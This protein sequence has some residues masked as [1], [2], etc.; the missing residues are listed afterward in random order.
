M[1]KRKKKKKRTEKA[2]EGTR[3]RESFSLVP[4][5]RGLT[6]PDWATALVIRCVW[7]WSWQTWSHMTHKAQTMA[8]WHTL[9]H[10]NDWHRHTHTHNSASS[11][12]QSHTHKHNLT[13]KSPVF[14]DPGFNHLLINMEL[15]CDSTHQLTQ[16]TFT[17]V[18]TLTWNSAQSHLRNRF[19]H[20]RQTHTHT[21]LSRSAS[22]TG[23]TVCPCQKEREKER[24]RLLHWTQDK[25]KHK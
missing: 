21:R 7:L 8:L 1:L 16:S 12:Q 19:I 2:S 5:R 18:I 24:E 9:T 4:T 3:G 23:R 15:L 25:V 11:L 14:P 22:W 20:L 13:H 17:W 6:G 10:K